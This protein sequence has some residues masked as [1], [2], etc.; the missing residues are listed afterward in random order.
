MAFEIIQHDITKVE[1]EAIVNAANNEL[2]RGGG[3]CGAIFAAAGIEQLTEACQTI[4]YCK[5]GDAVITDAFSLPARY[6]IHTV[7]P[8]WQG[9]G[10]GESVALQKCYENSLRLAVQYK[11]E[12]IAFP[13]ISSGIYGYP[14]REALEIA[15]STIK[16]FLLMNESDIDVKLVV[17]DR[18]AVE[19]SEELALDVRR[20]LDRYYEP[21][22]RSNL[23]P[24]IMESKEIAFRAEQMFELDDTYF[25]LDETFSEKLLRFIDER[26]LRDPDVYKRANVSRKHFSKIRNNLDYNPMKKTVIAFAIALQLT[27]EETD[28]LLGA[29]GYALSNSR[30]FDVIIKYFIERK[31]YDIFKINEVLFSFDEQL[32]GL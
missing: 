5:T 11:C 22:I 10:Q 6:I 18:N 4:G 7:G 16:E 26:G 20:Y 23:E 13:L 12:S 32:L 9:G 1:V 28:E 29:A 25:E 8:V 19:I 31:T 24:T 2:I 14:K 30:K 27:I 15:L 17:F 21:M 3:V